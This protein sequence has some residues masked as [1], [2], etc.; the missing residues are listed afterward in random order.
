MGVT[1]VDGR[2]YAVIDTHP[3]PIKGTRYMVPYEK[4]YDKIMKFRTVEYD[5]QKM[6]YPQDKAETTGKEPGQEKPVSL[7]L[8]NQLL[9]E[10][11]AYRHLMEQKGI[12]VDFPK[13]KSVEGNF[14]GITEINGKKFGVIDTHPDPTKGVRYMVPYTSEMDKLLKFRTVAFDG[15]QMSYV[16][17]VKDLIKGIGKGFEK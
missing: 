3:D 13:N 16:Q 5:G 6:R 2:K 14:M 10:E 1:E 4:E 7:T 11:K 12:T 15:K 8:D 17:T 9:P